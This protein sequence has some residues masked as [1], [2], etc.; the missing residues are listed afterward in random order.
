MNDRVQPF[1]IVIEGRCDPLFLASIL[2]N[3]KLVTPED[4]GF[5][6]MVGTTTDRDGS[7]R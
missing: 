4:G 5:T 6:L 1:R 3:V 2:E 7:E